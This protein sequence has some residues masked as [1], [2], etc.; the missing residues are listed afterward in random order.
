M[1][2]ALQLVGMWIRDS[3]PAPAEPFPHDCMELT[4]TCQKCEELLEWN[5]CVME[6]W[7]DNFSSFFEACNSAQAA[8]GHYDS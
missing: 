4:G 7:K 5:D 2:T 6:E 8:T 1:N 3:K